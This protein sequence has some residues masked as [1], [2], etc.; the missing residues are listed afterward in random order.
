MTMPAHGDPGRRH[1]ATAAAQI[2]ATA[3]RPRSRARSWS[4]RHMAAM[5][6][7]NSVPA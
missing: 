1:S 3:A 5:S 4:L 2:S 6:T 7:S